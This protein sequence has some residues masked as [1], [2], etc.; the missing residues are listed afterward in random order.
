MPDLAVDRPFVVFVAALLTAV[1]SYAGAR[2]AMHSDALLDDPNHRS[3]HDHATSRAGGL[4][5]LAACIAGLFTV[6]VFSGDDALAGP[7]WRFLVLGVAAGLVGFADDRLSLTPAAK[8]AGQIGV[9]LAFVLWVGPVQS[10]AVPFVGDVALGAFGV[11]LAVFWIVAFLNIFNFMDGVNG[12]AG[13]AAAVG[14]GVFAGVAA[15]SGA[16]AAA[17][18]AGLVAVAALG[19][20][21]ANVLRGRLFMGDCGSHFLAFMIAGL[22]VFAASE[23][24]HHV[25]FWVLPVIFAP[26]IVDVAFTLVHRTIRRR[27]IVTAHREHIYQLILRSGARH[28]GVAALYSGAVAWCA[29][30]AIFMLT[31]P[32]SMMWLVPVAVVTL[33]LGVAAVVFGAAR[34]RGLLDAAIPA[35]S[36]DAPKAQSSARSG[37]A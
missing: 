26:F 32:P 31:L 10:L 33:L 8:L 13:G 37:D 25:S 36:G 19:F 1:V 16:H 6:A 20:L 34:R 17:I 30:A 15:M 3:S 12:I 9:A 11:L 27:N 24:D 23:G 14:L 5:I 28:A 2:L 29:A 4:A 7:A 35:P 22:A 21:P 18:V